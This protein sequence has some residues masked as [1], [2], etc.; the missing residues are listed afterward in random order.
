LDTG[1]GYCVRRNEPVVVCHCEL[2]LPGFRLV[3]AEVQLVVTEPIGRDGSVIHLDLHLLN[4][5]LW[6]SDMHRD[7]EPSNGITPAELS[8]VGR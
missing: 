8:V 4:G 6:I 7:E 3:V 2:D 5:A 1:E